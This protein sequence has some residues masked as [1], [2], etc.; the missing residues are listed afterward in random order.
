MVP[1]GGPGAGGGT[2]DAS[3]RADVRP[4]LGVEVRR[5]RGRGSG[6]IVGA[7]GEGAKQG[8]GEEARAAEEAAGGALPFL[9]LRSSSFLLSSLAGLWAFSSSRLLEWVVA[10]ACWRFV[11]RALRATASSHFR[12]IAT[13]NGQRPVGTLTTQLNDLI[14]LRPPYASRCAK[15]NAHPASRPGSSR[16][17]GPAC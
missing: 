5:C 9:L 17:R 16:R 13:G 14:S 12:T 10:A 15:S 8:G 4:A 7:G 1:K 6:A 3:I 2:G 11:G